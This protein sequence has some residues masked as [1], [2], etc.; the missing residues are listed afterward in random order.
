MLQ[1]MHSIPMVFCNIQLFVDTLYNSFKLSTKILYY[2]NF[3]IN[4]D[5]LN[6]Q[7]KF[8]SKFS[9]P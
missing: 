6:S 8:F 2:R 7:S 5:F 9:T 4:M 3:N 1:S